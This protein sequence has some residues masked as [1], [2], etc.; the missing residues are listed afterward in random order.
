MTGGYTVRGARRGNCFASPPM[1]LPRTFLAGL[2]CVAALPFALHACGSSGLDNGDAGAD[3]TANPP[4][5]DATAD[6][7][8][9]GDS[10]QNVGTD[11]SDAGARDA[12]GD[13]GRDETDDGAND[14]G[15]D[16][17]VDFGDAATAFGCEGGSPLPPDAGL[18]PAHICSFAD[19]SAD[20]PLFDKCCASSDDCAIGVYEFSCCGD[21]LAL[22]L[23]K[24]QTQPFQA[25]VSQ[26]MCA[27][28]GCA[29]RGMHTED[30]EGG[31]ADAGVRCDR[32]WCM[33]YAR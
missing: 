6:A 2:A 22:G 17:A 23:N 9:S 8:G 31:V 5:N 1:N 10:G 15:H 13:A 16:T 20:F 3:A 26:W 4:S 18:P 11:A 29:G 19:G 28:C 12:G 7:G 25:A 32:G 14:S 27:A 21:T 24:S 30:G 33:T